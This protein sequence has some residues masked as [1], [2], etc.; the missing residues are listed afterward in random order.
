MKQSYNIGLVG[1]I[2]E[3]AAVL[4]SLYREDLLYADEI[5]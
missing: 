3:G 4:T 2:Y 1:N 5:G